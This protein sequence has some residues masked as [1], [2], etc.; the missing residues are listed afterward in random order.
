MHSPSQSATLGPPTTFQDMDD[1]EDRNV[2]DAIGDVLYRDA[3]TLEAYLASM[4]IR[5]LRM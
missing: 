4:S 5:N 2:L 1:A 3:L